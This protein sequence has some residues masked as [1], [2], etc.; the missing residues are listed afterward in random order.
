M[1][2]LRYMGLSG[3]A[4]ASVIAATSLGSLLGNVARAAS[5]LAGRAPLPP[6]PAP[7]VVAGDCVCH[8]RCELV[9]AAP[10][11]EPPGGALLWAAGQ[12]ALLL[13]IALCA[14]VR[15]CC[16]CS[17]LV[18]AAP[19]QQAAAPRV[20]TRRQRVPKELDALAVDASTL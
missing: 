8:C 20:T 10:P 12:F 16:R 4:V 11:W 9:T 3:L 17:R 2:V 19:R 18:E 14:G 7:E 1:R 15:V 13:V 5:W 6:V